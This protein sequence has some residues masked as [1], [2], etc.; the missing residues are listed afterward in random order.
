MEYN[1]S[2]PPKK[3]MKSP[4]KEADIIDEA[5][6]ES[7]P[8]SDPPAHTPVTSSGCIR[9]ARS[10]VLPVNQPPSENSK[11]VEQRR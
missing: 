1:R 11:K 8:A 9:I 10:P 6:D 3:G 4:R 2:Q 5:I 7:F